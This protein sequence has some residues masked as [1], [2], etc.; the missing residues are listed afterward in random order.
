MIY[1]PSQLLLPRERA[2]EPFVCLAGGF[3]GNLNYTDSWYVPSQGRGT[4]LQGLT[5]WIHREPHSDPSGNLGLCRQ[6]VV[7]TWPKVY[8]FGK[9]G[10]RDQD[11]FRCDE[12]H[13]IS[14]KSCLLGPQTDLRRLTFPFPGPCHFRGVR[15]WGAGSAAGFESP[16]PGA[17]TGQQASLSRLCAAG[18]QKEGGW[19]PSSPLPSTPASPLHPSLEGK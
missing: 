18:P 7:D 17:W 15:G 5:S 13:L 6:T 12:N 14:L 9:N 19:G 10:R 8:G 2:E 3:Y 4:A 16:P 11:T 1:L